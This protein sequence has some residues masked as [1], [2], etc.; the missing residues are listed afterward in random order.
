MGIGLVACGDDDDTEE[1]DTKSS[2][3]A[4]DA[5]AD[6]T[7]S[8]DFMHPF[9]GVLTCLGLVHATDEATAQTACETAKAGTQDVQD[10][11]LKEG[12]CENVAYNGYCI[13]AN[14]NYVFAPKSPSHEVE[15]NEDD[16]DPGVLQSAAWGCEKAP[17]LSG[18]EPGEFFCTLDN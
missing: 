2:D 5:H 11:V 18:T 14:G 10:P 8:C 17:E 7:W 13:A 3:V 16:C 9:S 15:T 4:I 1:T 12:S 6:Y